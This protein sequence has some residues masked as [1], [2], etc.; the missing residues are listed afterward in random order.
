MKKYIFTTLAII[1]F[2]GGV[3]FGY[4]LFGSD[5]ATESVSSE[6]I[7]KSLRNEEFLVT[8]SY[9]ADETVGI[10]NNTGSSFKDFFWGHTIEARANV[11][12]SIGIDLSGL[13]TEDVVV[14][15]DVVL[16]SLPWPELYST[17]IVGD[18]SLLNEQGLFKTLFDND[19]GYNQAVEKLKSQAYDNSLSN[20]FLSVE[21]RAS[22]KEKISRLVTFIVPEKTIDIRFK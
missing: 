10:E 19:Y 22:A 21:A 18:V 13:T 2:L 5:E 20:G 9:I 15:E 8:L 1:L 14:F 11:K 6:A 7:L 4:R 16:L 3:F 12:I 17:E